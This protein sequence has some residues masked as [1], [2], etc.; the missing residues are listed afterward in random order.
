MSATSHQDTARV[1][2][3]TCN[4]SDHSD[5]YPPEYDRAD[6]KAQRISYYARFFPIVEVDSTFYRLQPARNFQLWAERTPSGFVFNVK[7]YGEMTWHQRDDNGKPVEPRAETFAA[8]SEMVAPLRK[9][10]KLRAIH[11]QFPP[12]FTYSR[13]NLDYLG[14]VRE[15]LPDD[16]LSVEFRHRSWLE[17][18]NCDNTAAALRDHELA[19]TVVDQPQLGSGS[20]PPVVLVTNPHLAIFRFHGRNRQTWYAKDLK[21]S[22]ERFDYLYSEQELAEWAPRIASVAER[23]GTSGEVH[24]LLNNNNRNYAVVNAIDMQ[25]LLGQE[26]AQ[27]QPLPE[28]VRQTMAERAAK[29]SAAEASSL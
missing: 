17:G 29:Q 2:V 21:S 25:R 4:W 26:P 28:G 12:W 16:W 20:V 22:R 19:Y 11:F 6:M 13:E 10:G 1:L 23:L 15:L 5:F 3:G 18:R 7:A 27:G 14:T 9:A 24:V 8:F